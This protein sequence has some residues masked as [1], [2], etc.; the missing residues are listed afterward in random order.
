VHLPPWI[1]QLDEIAGHEDA[2]S[3]TV[4]DAVRLRGV[5]HVGNAT[6]AVMAT[7]FPASLSPSRASDFTT[8]PLLFR[9]SSIDRLPEEPSA[10]AGR[11]TLVHRALETLFDLPAQ[12]RTLGA[13]EGLVAQA[14]EELERDDP[15][16]A[17]TMRTGPEG[18]VAIDAAPL[19]STYFGMEDPTRLEPHAREV[20]VSAQL[21]E[22]FEVRGFIDRVDR[23]PAGEIRI[24]DYKTGRSPVAGFEAKAMFQMRFY[25][26]AWWRMTDEMPR[27][28][29]LMYLGN[30]E[31]LRH[32]PDEADLRSTERKVLALRDAIG[33]A[34][35][36]MAFDATPSRLCDW[37]SHRAVCPA[38]GGSPPPLPARED[39]PTS[40]VR[41]APQ[42]D[43]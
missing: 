13:A 10:P 3:A 37:C 34:A 33:R 19:L 1:G 28:L 15:E 7:P 36:A 18:S 8:C 22:S 6:V 17:E 25:A 14:F 30:G 43:D 42:I 11:G 29:Q 38:W 40:S 16:S 9:F 35:D 21:E 12:D 2:A 24:V 41:V 32:E 4:G 31:V 26:L 20:G 27:R 39:W 5:R 23:S